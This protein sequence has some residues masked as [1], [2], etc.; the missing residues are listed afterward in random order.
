MYGDHDDF[1]IHSAILRRELA[2]DPDDH[3]TECGALL[4]SE[5][6]GGGIGVGIDEEGWICIDCHNAFMADDDE[7]T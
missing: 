3:C 1:N 4:T 6:D 2:H 7:A 5:N